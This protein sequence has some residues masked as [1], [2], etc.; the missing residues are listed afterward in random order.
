M[1]HALPAR[2]LIVAASVLAAGCPR[3]PPWDTVVPV[4]QVVGEYNANAAPVPRLWAR[5]KIRVWG[6]DFPIAWGSTSPLAMPNGLLILW[7]TPDRLGPQDFVLM[8]REM[9]VDV[10]RLGSS[11]SGSASASRFRYTARR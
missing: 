3:C 6:E 9:G 2:I 4:D 10:F 1:R 7:K 5:V 11:A 8:G